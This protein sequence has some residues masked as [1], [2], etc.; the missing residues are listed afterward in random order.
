VQPTK[1]PLEPSVVPSG[2]LSA[3]LCSSVDEGAL[4]ALCGGAVRSA[5]PRAGREAPLDLIEEHLTYDSLNS[6]YR[7]GVHGG[8]LIKNWYFPDDW[9]G[10]LSSE[11]YVLKIQS[12]A[13]GGYEATVRS[14]DLERIGDA[15]VNGGKRGKREAP[16]VVSYENQQKA[17]SRSKR[18]MRH[19]VK[20][21][22]ADH[23]VTFTKRESDSSSFWGAEQW[24]KAW[25]KFRRHLTRYLGEF[26]YVAILEKHEKGNY[27]L[28]V[29]WCG[30]VN[31]GLVRKMWLAALG[32]GKG[33]G[34]IDA[35]HIK[36]PSGGDR[37]AR[38]ARYISKYVGKHFDADPRY[39]KKRYWSSRQTLEEA[40]RYVLK[41]DTL[42]G[43]IEQMRRML[44][45]DF[46]KFTRLSPNRGLVTDNLFAFPDGSGLWLGYVPELHGSD[47]PF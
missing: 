21:M 39:N 30:R 17:A 42:D 6:E 43:A 40:R 24:S 19:L 13:K 26:P 2:C 32:G 9:R 29:A 28:H 12:F 27:H 44:G 5:A 45:L 34:N 14:V 7:Q 3:G 38:I 37:A 25:D 16:D 41:A 11:T 31:V 4:G 36:V 23:L 1:Y 33:C 47:P 35:K 18:K 10:A 20:N 8:H 22:M 15:I 46:S